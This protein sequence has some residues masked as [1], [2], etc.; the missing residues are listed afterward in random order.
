MFFAVIEYLATLI[1]LLI[2]DPR[3]V[4]GCDLVHQDQRGRARRSLEHPEFKLRIDKDLS[5][6]FIRFFEK[7]KGFLEKILCMI[8]DIGRRET[9]GIVVCA[10]LIRLE[11]GIFGFGDALKAEERAFG[12]GCEQ[13]GGEGLIGLKSIGE[14]DA[15]EVALPLLVSAPERACDV[16]SEDAFKA[17]RFGDTDDPD[18]WMGRF[19]D[20]V[21]GDVG[22][23]ESLEEVVG[24]GVECCAFVG[25]A[26]ESAFCVP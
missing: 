25:D 3:S 14:V 22:F 18:E 17:Q 23:L 15:V 2:P 8:E 12:G 11:G 6:L 1:R 9:E 21:L 19:E 24:D 7:K 4:G 5:D 26:V 10:D 16:A 20:V 13:K